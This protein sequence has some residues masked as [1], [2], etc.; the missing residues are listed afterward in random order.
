MQSLWLGPLVVFRP[1]PEGQVTA[2]VVGL[3]EVQATAAT[4]AEALQG[5]RQVLHEWLEAGRLIP[6]ETPIENPWRRHAGWA[7]NDPEYGEFLDQIHR[8]RQEV[9][10]QGA[11]E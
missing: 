1:E 2:Q 6:L 8:Q 4:R 7:K 5:V 9:E 10:N 11:Q 3:P